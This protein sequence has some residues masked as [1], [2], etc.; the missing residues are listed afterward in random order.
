MRV[1]EFPDYAR[2]LFGYIFHPPEETG[3]MMGE[4]KYDR[5]RNRTHGSN[6]LASNVSEI[7]SSL[8]SFAVSNIK[9]ETNAYNK[10]KIR[11]FC[12][13]RRGEIK[14]MLKRAEKNKDNDPF[15]ANVLPHLLKAQ[16]ELECLGDI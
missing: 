8:R 10:L 14:G 13:A 6:E 7:V 11:I 16:Q 12:K 9:P 15:A 1:L 3:I 4:V 5:W 2:A